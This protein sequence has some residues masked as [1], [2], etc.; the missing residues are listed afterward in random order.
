MGSR[1]ELAGILRLA[2]KIASGL[3][4]LFAAGEAKKPAISEA[5][6]LRA[7]LWPPWS[8]RFCDAI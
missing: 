4:F 5:E 3:R 7:R 1:C 8:L 2:P 6:W